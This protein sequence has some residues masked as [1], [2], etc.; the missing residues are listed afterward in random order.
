MIDHDVNHPSIIIW[1]NGNE[2]G[3]NFELD[4]YFNNMIFKNVLL[5]IPGNY[6]VALKHSIT[7]NTIMVSAIMKMEERL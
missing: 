5:F 3:H 1:A 6:L 2:G 4:N 7:G